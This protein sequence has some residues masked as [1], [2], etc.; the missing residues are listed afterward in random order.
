MKFC[1]AEKRFTLIEPLVVIAII[2]ILAAMLLPA[3][4]QARARAQA[5]TCIN[6]LKQLTVYAGLY[7]NDN[8]DQWCSGN[9]LSTDNP[10][11]PYVYAMGRGGY[12]SS[13]YSELASAKSS[14]LRCPTIGLKPEPEVDPGQEEH[15]E[16]YADLCGAHDQ[17]PPRPVFLCIFRSQGEARKSDFDKCTVYRRYLIVRI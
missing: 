11:V 10:I 3:L 9:S 6:N 5:S 14:F 7:R 2:A 12:W 8:R 15:Q 4:Q 13:K 1:G 16:E 17:P